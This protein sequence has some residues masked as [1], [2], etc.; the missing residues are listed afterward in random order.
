M[1]PTS[2]DIE[3]PHPILSALRQMIRNQRPEPRRNSSKFHFL[4]ITLHLILQASL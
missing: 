3:K 4:K 2:I 1:R